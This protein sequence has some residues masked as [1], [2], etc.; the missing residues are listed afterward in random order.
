MSET[1]PL[2]QEV[3]LDGVD[4]S[5]PRPRVRWAAVMWGLLLCAAAGAITLIGA[6]DDRREQF[7]AW[8]LQ[9]TP[10]A[11]LLVALVAI[12]GVILVVAALHLMTQAQAGPRAAEATSSRTGR[13]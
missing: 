9:L 6:E 3:G 7:V 2:Q 1:D 13:R 12:G 8:L 11:I 10:T 4:A 5:L